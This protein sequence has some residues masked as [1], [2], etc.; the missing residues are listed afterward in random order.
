MKR[1]SVRHLL[2]FVLIIT[3]GISVCDAQTAGSKGSKHSGKG[4]SGIFSGK[5]SDSKI[6][7]PKTASQVKKEQ[8][9]KDK[10]LNED[11]AKSVKESQKR[12]I[13]IQTPDVQ[14]RMKQDKKD[15]VTR[16]KGRKKNTSAAT[17]KAGRKYKK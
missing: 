10:K 1:L 17:R 13:K 5:R 8:A 14:H 11:Y 6:K 9:K 2:V 3:I 16:E 12:T 15:I 4:L 7:K